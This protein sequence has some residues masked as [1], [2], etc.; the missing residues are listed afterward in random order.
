MIIDELKPISRKM[1]KNGNLFITA[2][3]RKWWAARKEVVMSFINFPGEGL[4][5]EDSNII[6]QFLSFLNANT[7]K[8]MMDNGRVLIETIFGGDD[9]VSVFNKCLRLLATYSENLR[10]RYFRYWSKM[11]HKLR[12]LN[13][14][15]IGILQKLLC[16][17][18]VLSPHSM[19][20]EKV[21]SDCNYLKSS[22]RVSTFDERMNFTV[23][24]ALNSIRTTLRSTIGSGQFLMKKECCYRKPELPILDNTSNRDF[25][26]KFLRIKQIC[27][28]FFSFY[29]FVSFFAILNSVYYCNCNCIVEK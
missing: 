10:P 11:S 8:E 16:S 6:K 25:V 12:K 27:K 21:I 4:N 26:K 24:V 18:M 28:L 7:R 20:V 3:V 1:R 23:F 29:I 5:I 15:K 17:L 14:V 2:G 13:P 9:T 19:T 22:H